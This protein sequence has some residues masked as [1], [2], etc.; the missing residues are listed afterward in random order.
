LTIVEV[1]TFRGEGAEIMLNTGKVDKIYCIDPWKDGYGYYWKAERKEY[2]CMGYIE[3][4][5]D[6]R[7]GSEPR[8]I[9]HKGILETFSK[10]SDENI[11]LVYI[12]ALTDYQSVKHYIE[13]SKKLCPCFIGG[14]DY[15]IN[16]DFGGVIKAVIEAFT[17]PDKKFKDTSWIVKTS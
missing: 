15:T 8:I 11:D 13:A 4:D 3:Q 17:N 7:F 9:K 1:G 5:F 12:D 14:H 2:D 10:Q 16:A 6:R